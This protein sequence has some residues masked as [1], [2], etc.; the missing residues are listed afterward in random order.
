MGRSADAAPDPLSPGR[1]TAGRFRTL[2]VAAAAL[3]L[4]VL[5]VFAY[6]LAHAQ[7]QSRH[8]VERRF[9]D[10]ALISAAVTESLFSVSLGS[11]RTQAAD[12]FGG[13]TVSRARLDQL[14]TQGGSA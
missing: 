4:C 2:F 13:A 10:R 8:D 12:R 3:T 9:R 1:V 11:T 14:V 7:S 6:L 5:A